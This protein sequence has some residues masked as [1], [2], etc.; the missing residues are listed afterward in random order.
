MKTFLFLFCL[1]FAFRASSAG[2][3]RVLNGGDQ[4]A[5]QFINEARSAIR[6]LKSENMSADLRAIVKALDENIDLVSVR[7]VD[8]DLKI[9]NDI[10][11]AINMPGEKKI[12]INRTRIIR[13][14]ALGRSNYTSIVLHEYLGVSGFDDH[15]YKI[16]TELTDLV[17]NKLNRDCLDLNYIRSLKQEL[18]QEFLKMSSIGK[19]EPAR[20]QFCFT[21]NYLSAQIFNPVCQIDLFSEKEIADQIVF[22]S[23]SAPALYEDAKALAFACL[24]SGE[25]KKFEFENRLHRVLEIIGD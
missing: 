22:S 15:S 25:Q 19:N 23:M 18:Q 5:Q 24:S 7:S 17:K 6:L 10:V 16:S 8:S 2:G 21:L 3:D 13:D 20:Q 1:F 14:R 12:F 9:K 4:L 11:D